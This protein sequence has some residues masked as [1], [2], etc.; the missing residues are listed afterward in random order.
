[1]V[2]TQQDPEQAEPPVRLVDA[3]YI[4]DLHRRGLKL[5]RR[6]DMPANA[7]LTPEEIYEAG[8]FHGALPVVCISYPWRRLL[9]FEP[10]SPNRCQSPLITCVRTPSYAVHPFHPDPNGFHLEI[11]A[12]AL[13]AFINAKMGLQPRQ[14]LAVFW[15]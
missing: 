9:H 4:V 12:D 7:F 10:L 14:R 8:T 13:E 11:A 3:Q 1:M 15:E 5:S 2:L 6:Q